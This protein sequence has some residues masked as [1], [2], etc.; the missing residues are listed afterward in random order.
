VYCVR[1][2]ERDRI[3]EALRSREIACATY[4]STPLHR[5]PALGPLGSGEESLPETERAARD[6]VALPLWPGITA[7]QQEQVVG[8]VRS[9]L[10][11]RA[12]S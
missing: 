2:P 5:Q 6:T 1:T 7:D 8:C 9:A 3:V 12:V 4:Y 11:V 10:A